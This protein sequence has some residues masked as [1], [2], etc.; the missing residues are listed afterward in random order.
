MKQKAVLL[1]T[2]LIIVSFFIVTSG[3]EA[4]AD[5][6]AFAGGDGSYQNPY[7]IT[8]EAQLQ[9]IDA[10]AS[11]LNY[12]QIMND[13]ELT[14]PWMPIGN[15]SNPFKG[16]LNGNG[17][18]IS[19]LDLSGDYAAIGLI[20]VNEGMV[21]SLFIDSSTIT[22]PSWDSDMGFVVGH[23]TGYVANCLVSNSEVVIDSKSRDVVAE[24]NIGGIVG[25]NEGDVTICD[26][27]G[28]SI[29][30]KHVSYDTVSDG[31][32]IPHYEVQNNMHV[33]GIAG[34]SSGTITNCLTDASIDV[35]TYSD[36]D[37]PVIYD[38]GFEPIINSYVGGI[39]GYSNWEGT[40]S[41]CAFVNSGKVAGEMKAIGKNFMGTPSSYEFC[42]SG[43]DDVTGYGTY[44]SIALCTA[45]IGFIQQIVYQEW[46]YTDDVN[47]FNSPWYIDSSVPVLNHVYLRVD[48]LPSKTKY[49]FDEPFS[50]DGLKISCYNIAG[51]SME[52]EPAEVT[53]HFSEDMRSITVVATQDLSISIVTY[54]IEID[55]E[56]TILSEPTHLTYYPGET[57]DTAG[58]SIGYR[59]Y[60]GDEYIPYTDYTITPAIITVETTEVI[61]HCEGYEFTLPI[62]IA[63]VP[64][65]AVRI[66][67]KDSVLGDFVEYGK[68][69]EQLVLRSLTNDGKT[70]VGWNTSSDGSGTSYGPGEQ[71]TIS[72]ATTL[73]AMWE[74]A[75]KGE[76]SGG[77]CSF[78]LAPAIAALIIAFVVPIA[79]VRW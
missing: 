5:T 79:L 77:W 75:S 29:V 21:H 63:S 39:V 26:T 53:G 2:V 27:D 34:Y 3:D 13:I 33:G 69:G 76:D 70:F 48:D 24:L 16:I 71:Y 23:N 10:T 51:G 54:D 25:L 58:L 11:G 66:T 32:H 55:P 1:A 57:F 37:G 36:Y 61:I 7:Q 74:D 50:S 30:A 60:S 49:G 56:W 43:Y 44:D 46:D 78:V 47:D 19:G 31:H 68:I 42:S 72:G 12:Y 14:K 4:E 67:F 65:D 62:T 41:D 64:D 22:S 20:G 45:E 6:H 35:K 9:Y 38:G 18:T 73:Y 52:F 40:L 8:N 59:L 28:L 17:Y 15:E